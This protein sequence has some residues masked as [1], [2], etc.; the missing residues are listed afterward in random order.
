MDRKIKLLVIAGPT[1]SGKSEMAVETALL[2]DA[3]IINA[4]SVQVYRHF[5]IGAAKP[6]GDL[7]EAIPHHLIDIVEPDRRFT[8][9]DFRL[10]AQK[11]I[12]EITS[13]G[14]N[15]VL[16]GGT[17]LYLK[18][19]LENM[20]GGVKPDPQLRAELLDELE[21]EGLG[22]LFEKL[23][24]IDPKKA[25]KIHPN[26][27]HR[28]LRALES[29]FRPRRA[30]AVEQPP[31]AFVFFI[32]GGPRKLLYERIDRRVTEMFQAG[33]IEEAR[34][35]LARGYGAGC[36]PFGSVGYRQVLNYLDGSLTEEELAPLVQKETRHYAKRQ[37]TWLNR[38]KNGIWVDSISGANSDSRQLAEFLADCYRN[39]E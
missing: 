29:A 12:G 6:P 13:R 23:N 15:V 21:T 38:V 17:G 16:A 14:K 20:D 7:L 26:D 30:E 18:A 27:R 22:F 10:A 34:S 5:N 39:A 11:A 1:G 32:L 35:I 2:L 33:W 19:L 37:V 4:D 28:V 24:K 25:A 3:E 8:M 31:Y 36:K 9:W